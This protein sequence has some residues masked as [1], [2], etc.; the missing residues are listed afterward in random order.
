M[1]LKKMNS[2]QDVVKTN[3]VVGNG[4]AGKAGKEKSNGELHVDASLPAGVLM[5]G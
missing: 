4:G 1:C 3:P 5:K 2:A